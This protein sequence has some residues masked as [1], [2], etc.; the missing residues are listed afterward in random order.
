[1]IQ[2]GVFLFD[3][4]VGGGGAVSGTQVVVVLKQSASK[5]PET[6]AVGLFSPYVVLY[7]VFI[8]GM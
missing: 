6:A 7:C 1:M 5:W 3:L 8:G 2:V 4:F